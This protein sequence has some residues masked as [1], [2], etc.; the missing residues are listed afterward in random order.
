MIPSPGLSST[1][2]IGASLYARRAWTDALID[3]EQ[4]GVDIQDA[5]LG[6]SIKSW[7]LVWNKQT[8]DFEISAAGV[9]TTTPLNKTDVKRCALS[10]DQNMNP[11]IAWEDNSG[12][13]LW[14]FDT[15]IPAYTIL[16]QAG[17]YP[18]LT[19]DDKHELATLAGE[20]DMLWLYVRSGSLYYRQQRDRFTIEYLIATG[21]S[22]L[23]HAGMNKN[24]RMQFAVSG[25]SEVVPWALGDVVWD[26]CLQ[27]G[28]DP[29]AIDVSELYED[30]VRGM[31][32]EQDEGLAEPIDW[33]RASYFFD[34]SAH[35]K[36]LFFPKRG[37]EVVAYIPYEDLVAGNPT[38][39]GQVLADELKLPKEV[40]IEHLDPDGGYEKNK[41]TASRRSNMVHARKKESIESN[42]VLTASEAATTALIKLKSYYAELIDYKFKTTI[43]YTEL[44]TADV[45]MVEDFD[46]SW[47]RIRIEEKNED[48]G[49][50]SF[51]GKQDGG[52]Y[53]YR[54]T[55]SL[56]GNPLPP[57]VSTTPGLISPTRLEIINISPQ[58][59][60]DD[61]L[62]LYVAGCGS[63]AAWTGYVLLYS[64]DLGVSYSQA[65]ST[66]AEANIGDTVTDLE[67]DE[68]YIYPSAQTVEV[69]TRSTL[70]SI[71]Y[72]QL[73]AKMNRCIIG[74]EE[75]Q[76]QTATLLGVV[77]GKYHYL[78]SNLVRGRYNTDSPTWSAGAR[79]VL[80]DSN[81]IFVPIP[82]SQYQTELFYKAVSYG[83][84][85]DETT[86]LSY[87]FDYA[88]SQT[89]WPVYD[90]GSS[91]DGS[92][93]VTVTWKGRR[94]LGYDN[95][96]YNSK[97]FD[98]YRVKFS[99]GHIIN[100]NS[101]TA[102][103]NSAPVGV[104]V[105]VCAMNEI[106]GEGQYSDALS[107]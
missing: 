78:L 99:D 47:H 83:L 84:S 34:K 101:T 5:S 95:A 18:Y 55:K 102:T 82:K 11:A 75:L 40:S 31:K 48:T 97:Y 15:T 69:L 62:G 24:F 7:K 94:R 96:P 76:F 72:D 38:A 1:P 89:E 56:I 39:L 13:H 29:A 66:A 107:T 63:S 41:Q 27:A 64:P 53:V 28:I 98:G 70:S 100:T 8:G 60:A 37:R 71:T 22:K 77:G 61:E 58:T 57:P 59:D 103:Y 3:Y 74:D 67:E 91:R 6:L 21:I 88:A 79:F 49:I 52:A 4:G 46:G 25:G 30:F 2:M 86:P 104:T 68:G 42:L 44:T 54:N 87:D 23:Y 90:V 12:C 36:K 80:L 16:D 33:L 43:K 50:I 20:N 85:T 65:Y 26:L 73:L 35:D 106:T 81:V 51:D 14:W 45:I 10:F 9:T 105:Q 92:D 17:S 32:V 93:N 19:M